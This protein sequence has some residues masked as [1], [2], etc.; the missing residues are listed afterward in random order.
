MNNFYRSVAAKAKR[1]Q[2]PKQQKS[3]QERVEAKFLRF[4]ESFAVTEYREVRAI[5]RELLA[6]AEK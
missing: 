3:L 6:V 1:K 2:K 5:L 4:M